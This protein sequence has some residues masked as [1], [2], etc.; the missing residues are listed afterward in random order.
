MYTSHMH[1][2]EYPLLS[3]LHLEILFSYRYLYLLV[4]ITLCDFDK[5]IDYLAFSLDNDRPLR[6]NVSENGNS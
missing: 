1:E 4:S 6:I 3:L 2:T 5:S